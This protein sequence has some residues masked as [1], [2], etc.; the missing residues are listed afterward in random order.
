MSTNHSH[1]RVTDSL[2][3]RTPVI[4]GVGQF[5]NRVDQGAEPLSPVDLILEAT[6]IAES[7]A[8]GALANR[9]EV[10]ACV[11]MLSW[12]YQDPGALVAE[13]L[14]SNAATWYPSFGGNT[15][16]MMLNRLAGQIQAGELGIGLLVGAEAWHTRTSHKRLA[17]GR[18]G[19]KPD[20]GTQDP[21]VVPTWGAD[22]N[23]QMGGPAEHA[24]GILQPTQVYPMFET[25]LMHT[26]GLTP[27]E[28][29]RSVGEMWA[30]FSEVA[31]DNPNAWDRTAYSPEE[32]I[33]ATPENRYVGWPYTKHM[34]SNPA[35]D[36][37]SAVFICSVAA[38]RDAGI[39]PEQWVFI[40]SGSDCK[41]RGISER[42][43]FHHSPSITHGTDTAL[44]LAGLDL[45]E[46]DH[47]DVY[48]CFP[49]AVGLF[50]RAFGLGGTQRQLTVY[51][52]LCFAG[53]PWN[54]PVGHAI[55]SMVGVLREDPGSH[56]MVTANGGHVD[57]HS[58]GVYSTSP[59]P[60]GFRHG[61]PQAL[62]DA[63]PGR[64]VLQDYSGEVEV[65]TWTVMHDRDNQPE[66][67]LGSC[68]TPGG[69]R[70]W[71]SHDDPDLLKVATAEDLVGR[72]GRADSSGKLE[73]T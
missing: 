62:I 26:S 34:V 55:A 13:R 14:G 46:V 7:D 42:H 12:R 11:R 36:M 27:E 58:F 31:A 2:D 72:H 25:A 5:L 9:A 32:I 67:Y 54:N 20:W 41:D 66:R 52:G 71:V 50:T 49:S 3:P 4:V 68:L 15:P 65:E 56:G 29:L 24:R 38:A 33:T 35:V 64:T 61:S 23:F 22:D 63:E 51:G 19:D 57:K 37:A 48:S 1:H 8:G 70:V 30:G 39:P 53:G 28:H 69:E 47:L 6:K 44:G 45:A 60:D 40:H 21:S 43:N 59:P 16:Q 10:I 18:S 73:L 17:D